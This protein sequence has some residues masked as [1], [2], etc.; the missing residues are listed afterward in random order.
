MTKIKLGQ[1]YMSRFS[2]VELPLR[3]ER[4]NPTGGWTARALTH[5][6]TVQVKDETQLLYRLTEDEVRGIAQGVIP[7]RRS[8]IQGAVF[9][10]Q[11]VATTS[12]S[13][14]TIT[15]KKVKR[16]PIQKI[17]LIERLNILDAAERVL[18]ETKKPMTTREIIIVAKEKQYRTPPIDLTTHIPQ[19]L[20]GNGVVGNIRPIREPAS[21]VHVV[22]RN[23]SPDGYLVIIRP[24]AQ[25]KSVFLRL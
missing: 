1:C 19:L 20:N 21:S 18:A 15:L 7:N 24:V 16:P 9:R 23:S 25:L 3:I 6:R 2:K 11:T 12:E 5:G 10:E 17:I 13:V 4:V 14:E 8:A 22:V